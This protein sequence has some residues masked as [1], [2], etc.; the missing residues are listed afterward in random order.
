MLFWMHLHPQVCELSSHGRRGWRLRRGRLQNSCGEGRLKAPQGSPAS[1]SGWR[2]D[3]GL[4]SRSCTTSPALAGGLLTAGPTGRADTT[5]RSTRDDN[6][7]RHPCCHSWVL[8]VQGLCPGLSHT[9]PL[10][11]R[12]CS[13][14]VILPSRTLDPQAARR[15]VFQ[16][17]CSWDPRGKLG[18][19]TCQG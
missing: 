17:L 14:L 19:A 18:Q 7:H 13:V 9:Q 2:E 8:V 6:T 11:A 4:L 15:R 16:M 3:P 12:P 10:R 1:S 5:E